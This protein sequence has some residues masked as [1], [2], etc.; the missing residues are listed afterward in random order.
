MEICSRLAI[1]RDATSQLIGL[2]KAREIGLKLKRQLVKS[3]VW[4]IA[5]YGAECWTLKQ[6][7]MREKRTNA[8]IRKR[9]E[10]QKK[11]VGLLAQLRKRK[12]CMDTGNTDQTALLRLQQKG[13]LGQDVEKQ[14]ELITSGIG[15]IEEWPWQEQGTQEN[16]EGSIR[17]MVIQ[18]QQLHALKKKQRLII[19]RFPDFFIVRFVHLLR[20]MLQPI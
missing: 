8:W 9:Q 18:Q 13:R 2:Q 15:R 16:A 12:L 3:L 6:S 19:L 14:D 20:Q 7:D 5:L 1:A 4:S 17:T 11:K 10:S